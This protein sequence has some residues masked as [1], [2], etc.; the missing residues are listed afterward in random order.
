[1]Q[2][3]NHVVLLGDK[4]HILATLCVLRSSFPKLG[5]GSSSSKRRLN[6]ISACGSN[7]IAALLICCGVE[8]ETI[9]TLLIEN[10]VLG[11]PVD[12]KE[13]SN[14]LKKELKDLYGDRI[15]TMLQ[16]YELTRISLYLCVYNITHQKV[17]Y[18]SHLTHPSLNCIN[19]CLMTYNT[20]YEDYKYT[21]CG[22]EYIDASYIY[23]I[24]YDYVT[25]DDN[26]LCVYT[27][28]N[29]KN[30]AKITKVDLLEKSMWSG[31]INNTVHKQLNYT[32]RL[33]LLSHHQL[34]K[35]KIKNGPRNIT[36][37]CI[38]EDDLNTNN[39]KEY[40]TELLMKYTC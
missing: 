27:L 25:L 31:E 6:K 40:Q 38:Y 1:M 35:E 36:Y 21:Y 26:A 19:A 7:V 32:T 12:V 39:N 22:V 18:I 33:L 24:P 37:Q 9:L 8:L 5:S 3:Y 4:N 28:F 16:L 14:L 17:D 30:V 13:I 11:D 29:P 10:E 23:P 34:V 15:P 2:S 20:P